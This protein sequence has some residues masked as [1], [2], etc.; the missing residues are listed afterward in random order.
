MR[1]YAFASPCL[2]LL[3]VSMASALPHA[4][5]GAEPTEV[6]LYRKPLADGRALVVVR[7]PGRDPAALRGLAHPELPKQASAIYVVR[8]E[9]HAPGAPALLLGSRLQFDFKPEF[10]HEDNGFDV[11]DAFLG[12]GRCLL[13]TGEGAA[14]C[15]WELAMPGMANVGHTRLRDRAGAANAQRITRQQFRAAV[16]QSAD[17]K[18]TVEFVDLRTA[19]WEHTLYEVA[20]PR[21]EL[22]V[23]R[24][25]REGSAG[26][27]NLAPPGRE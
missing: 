21:L 14:A 11:L 16:K 25:W 9:L 3:S 12:G 13:V 23:V 7:E 1:G 10:G 20:E 17:G 15:V 8:V 6:V 22:R 26:D 5:A 24:K 2:M 19:V 27:N 4:A 18:L